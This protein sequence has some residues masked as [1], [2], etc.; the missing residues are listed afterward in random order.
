MAPCREYQTKM[1]RSDRDAPAFWLVSGQCGQFDLNA[2]NS[3]LNSEH[4][5][6]HYNKA[7]AIMSIANGYHLVELFSRMVSHNRPMVHVPANDKDYIDQ[8]W[9]FRPTGLNE[10]NGGTCCHWDCNKNNRQSSN[11]SQNARWGWSCNE[12][13]AS[14]LEIQQDIKEPNP[15]NRESSTKWKKSKQSR[16]NRLS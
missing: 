2:V 8:R 10:A 11:R 14:S 16:S 6:H 7:V 3:S 4:L 15:V 5:I 1:V 9:S 13:S 12:N